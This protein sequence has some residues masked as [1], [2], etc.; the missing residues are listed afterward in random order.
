MS[1]PPKGAGPRGTLPLGL[2]PVYSSPYALRHAERECRA[3]A[4]PSALGSRALQQAP[5]MP[6]SELPDWECFAGLDSEPELEIAAV[7]PH[8]SAKGWGDVAQ[9]PRAPAL[10]AP[11]RLRGQS[12][13]PL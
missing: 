1:V 6:E 10:R 4:R 11:V 12:F 7:E 9:A 3:T 8:R 13:A 5:E 2:R